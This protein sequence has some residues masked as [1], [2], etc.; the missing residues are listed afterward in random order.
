MQGRRLCY[1]QQDLLTLDQ[2]VDG[3]LRVDAHDVIH[4]TEHEHIL[5]HQNCITYMCSYTL[6]NYDAR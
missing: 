1:E 3:V 4:P 2:G 6:L 5:C